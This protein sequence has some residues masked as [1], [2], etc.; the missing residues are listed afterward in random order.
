SYPFANM[1]IILFGIPLALWKIMSNRTIAFFL[2]I[3]ICFFYWGVISMG[4]A[5]GTG[6]ILPPF[7]G[8]WLANMVFFTFSIVLMKLS[9]VV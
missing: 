8:A 4:Q 6:G 7:L 3:I 5:L 1:I 9:E 2:A